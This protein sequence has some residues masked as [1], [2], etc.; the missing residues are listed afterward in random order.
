M[1]SQFRKMKNNKKAQTNNNSMGIE[2]KRRPL[3][4]WEGK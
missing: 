3:L 2:R 4:C 1:Q